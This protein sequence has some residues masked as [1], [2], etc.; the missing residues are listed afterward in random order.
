MGLA[1]YLEN[2]G[3]GR[4]LRALNFAGAKLAFAEVQRVSL[5]AV[6]AHYG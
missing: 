1:D 5:A 3:F 6:V 4:A 2:F